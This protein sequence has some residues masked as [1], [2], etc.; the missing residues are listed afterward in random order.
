M[1][2]FGRIEKKFLKCIKDRFGGAYQC[3]LVLIDYIHWA[4]HMISRF[5]SGSRLVSVSFVK[6]PLPILCIVP[7]ELYITEWR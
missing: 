2:C 3:L 6:T 5:Q 7:F 1:I 4:V